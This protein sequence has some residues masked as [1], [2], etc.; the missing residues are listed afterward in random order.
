MSE[1]FIGEIRA[2]PYQ[3]A[4]QGWIECLGQ[5]CNIQQ[6]PQFQV[7]FAVIG[8]TYGGDGRTTFKLPNLQG[9]AVRG[10]NANA[11][12]I[13][14][15]VLGGQDG[16][17]IVTLGQSQLPKH[18]H[19]VQT[20]RINYA[21]GPTKVSNGPTAATSCPSGYVKINTTTTPATTLAY[22]AYHPKSPAAGASVTPTVPV[23]M[24]AQSLTASGGGGSHDNRQPYLAF[25][26]CICF[27]GIYPPRP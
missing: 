22:Q 21:S 26:L 3:F 13:G 9:L 23:N 27:D 12:G 2:F 17:N 16:T 7:L 15:V 25:R 20:E 10:V 24:A 1:C 14:P 11:P 5:T 18:G 8:N 4:P 6:Q 19:T